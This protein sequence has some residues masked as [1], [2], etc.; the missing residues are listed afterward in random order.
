MSSDEAGAR[1]PAPPRVFLSYSRADQARALAGALERTGVHAGLVGRPD[2]GGAAF[3]KTIGN[4]VAGQRRGARAV[5]RA[6]G[7][8]GLGAGQIRAR[9][10]HEEAGAVVARWHRP[11]LDFRQYQAIPLQFPHGRID[12]AS[13]RAVLRAQR[14]CRWPGAKTVPRPR[15]ARA[16]LRPRCDAPPP[17]A[18][19]RRAGRGGGGRRAGLAPRLVRRIPRTQSATTSRCCPSTASA[20][21]RPRPISPT[22]CPGTR[23]PGAQSN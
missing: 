5:V 18:G 19:E 1:E 6:L 11:P 2:R 20:A 10:R 9:P 13:L 12:D 7:G 16:R 3:A 22:A 14:C 21:I 15:R 8:V 4:R 23:D 17:A